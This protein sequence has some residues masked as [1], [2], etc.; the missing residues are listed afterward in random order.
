MRRLAGIGALALAAFLLLVVA[1]CGEGDKAGGA[2]AQHVAVV[3]LVSFN[4]D[5]DPQ[6]QLFANYFARESHGSVRVDIVLG[7]RSHD[8]QGEK[9]VI[10]DVRAGKAELA[11]VG[12]R[13]WESV[14]ISS[15]RA[16]V[17]PFLIDSYPLQRTVLQSSL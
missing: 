17:A 8:P 16:L 15:F 10:G 3:R 2:A 6:L 9:D 4:A 12:A 13:A 5:M 7:Y 11:W 14:G 1:A